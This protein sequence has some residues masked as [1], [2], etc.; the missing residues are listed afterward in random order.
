MEVAEVLMK[1]EE[2][3]GFTRRELLVRAILGIGA[4]ALT[5]LLAK[6]ERETKR[7]EFQKEIGNRDASYY[8][9][10]AG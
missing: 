5:P 4:I 10:L 7:E 1:R 3:K 6:R 2:R 8:R 9:R